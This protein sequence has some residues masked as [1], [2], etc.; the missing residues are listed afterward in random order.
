[1]VVAD[2]TNA[3]LLPSAPEKTIWQAGKC[4]RD[5]GWPKVTVVG[6]EGAVSEGDA[7]IQISAVPRHIGKL[8]P[9]DEIVVTKPLPRNLPNEWTLRAQ[10]KVSRLVLDL[11]LT[12]VRCDN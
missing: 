3:D 12:A 11:R 9:G 4:H 6:I 8:I 1:M 10:T 7:R 2:F 5:R